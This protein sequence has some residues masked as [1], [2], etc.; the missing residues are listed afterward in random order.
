[1]TALI[2]KNMK[3]VSI[4]LIIPFFLSVLT[5]PVLKRVGIKKSLLDIA[6]NNKLK[7]HRQAISYLGGLSFFIPYYFLLLILAP[8]KKNWH[9]GSVV[10]GICGILPFCI[11]LFDDI[12]NLTPY[13]RLFWQMLT[14]CILSFFFKNHLFRLNKFSFLFILIVIFYVVGA[15]NAVN[16]EDGIDGLAG[17]LGVLSCIGFMILSIITD[18]YLG[19]IIS[20]IMTGTLLGFLIFN[21]PPASIF[22]GD[23]GS[24][25]LGFILA[26]LALSFTLVNDWQ[27]FLGP[28]FIIGIPVF[29]AAYAI[30]RR[31]EKGIS[32]FQGDRSHFY[33]QLMQ[34]GLSVKKTV[35]IC[36]G[37][38]F[39][40]VGLGVLI[41]S[42]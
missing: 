41:Y 39:F 25:F 12:K 11:G 31:I 32:P 5:I 36:W 7:I 10:F 30:L 23:N 3:N 20:S 42:L 40:M 26:F 15:I 14:G 29:D 38:Q 6:E 9:S 19:V 2:L 17:G 18:Y 21:F 24:Y 33:D 22:M 27:M 16:M 37:L 8:L 13:W 34:A 28:I 1:M 4:F 35:L